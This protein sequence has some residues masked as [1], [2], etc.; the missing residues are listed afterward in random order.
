MKYH[1]M[2]LLAALP[3]G[4]ILIFGTP[5]L[6]LTGIS[7]PQ[8]KQSTVSKAIAS[9]SPTPSKAPKGFE[10]ASDS[11]GVQV[12]RRD[13][14]LQSYVTVLNISKGELRNLT[15]EVTADQKVGHRSLLKYWDIAKTQNTPQRQAK[16]VINGTFFARY[17]QPTDLAFGLKSDGKLITYGYGLKEFP[18]LNKTVAWNSSKIR[19]EP[20]AKTTFDGQ[21]P[22]VVGALDVNAG[23]RKNQF[24]PR[25]FIGSKGQQVFIFSSNYARQIDAVRT[26]QDFGAESIAMLDGGGSTGLVVD[27]VEM[28]KANTTVPHGIA[29]YS[30]RK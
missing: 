30:D 21:L 7:Q 8:S 5:I 10:L 27:G 6:S 9:A 14:G 24:L 12:Y 3:L 13:N 18:G 2:L 15:G 20:Y 23:K 25:T 28:L 16:V 1:P 4:G 29:I 22:N 26:L 11:A 17:N 19:I